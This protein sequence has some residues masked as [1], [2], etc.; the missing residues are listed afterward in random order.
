MRPSWLR[1]HRVFD[2]ERMGHDFIVEDAEDSDEDEWVVPEQVSELVEEPDEP[3]KK[4]VRKN[5]TLVERYE[6]FL[7][8]SVVRGKVVKVSYLQEQRL[9]VFVETSE[10]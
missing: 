6:N 1:N 4:K 5:M 9:G 7:Y 8:K 3:K 10:A 2:L